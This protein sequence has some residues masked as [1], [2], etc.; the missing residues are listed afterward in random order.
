MAPFENSFLECGNVQDLS[1]T[2]TVTQSSLRFWSCSS[3]K[4]C[5][6][7]DAPLHWNLCPLCVD[8]GLVIDRR[9]R[10]PFAR[11]TV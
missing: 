6:N 2:P 9:G 7:E 10:H 3:S 11:A 5:A 8:A 4:L 1:D